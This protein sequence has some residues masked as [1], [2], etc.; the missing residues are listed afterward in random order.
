MNRYIFLSTIIIAHVSVLM[1]CS[2]G[3]TQGYNEIRETHT[4]SN[5]EIQ[6]I[7]GVN[8]VPMTDDKVI[9]NQSVV[10]RNNK[11]VEIGPSQ[12]ITIPKNAK[13]IEG[14]D[15]YLMP[16]LADM[17]MHFRDDWPV[18]QLNLYLANGVTTVRSLWANEPIFGTAFEI[19]WRNEINHGHRIGPRI[20]TS[21]PIIDG[22]AI[23]PSRKTS[24]IKTTAIY[25]FV[26]NEAVLK[27]FFRNVFLYSKES[28][29]QL[30]LYH[31]EKS[32]DFLKAYSHLSEEQFNGL[33]DAAKD[34][35]MYVVGHIPY[36][37]GIDGIVNKGME[38]AHLE[39][40]LYNSM[41]DIQ[42]LCEDLPNDRMTLKCMLDRA[43]EISDAEIEKNLAQAIR[44]IRDGNIT[45][46]S[47]LVFDEIL[48]EQSLNLD[49]Y[50]LRSGIEFVP[51]NIK[52][53][54]AKGKS[55]RQS[56]FK[57]YEHLLVRWNKIFK[58][59]LIDLHKAG[60]RIVLGT[61]AGGG[62]LGI[63]PGFTVLDELEIFVNAGLTSFEAISTSTKNAAEVVELM[64]KANDFGTIEIGKRADFILL[65]KNPLDDVKN[66]RDKIGVMAAG[67]WYSNNSLQ[68]MLNPSF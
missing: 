47:T 30:V 56:M 5:P 27:P 19:K 60:V 29:E 25:Q 41:G 38:I 64:G 1:S 8:L 59:L 33:M 43:Q 52:E 6:V 44:K 51:E 16:G 45:V 26:A 36:A 31:K 66:I 10:I 20:Y 35:D 39:E 28:A 23:L 37:V 7:N 48:E 58:K 3:L 9:K 2:N 68:K 12:S 11:I 24:F 14:E 21:G 65:N 49:K 42:K 61:D 34:L 32:Y 46:C 57:G 4:K 22:T 18:P 13:V 50:F 63:I 62:Y 40:I 67:V 55:I 15:G 54:I 53:T 17:H